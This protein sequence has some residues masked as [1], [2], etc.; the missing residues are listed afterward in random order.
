MLTVILM[1][2]VTSSFAM[3]GV[4]AI[5]GGAVS[6]MTLSRARRERDFADDLDNVLTEILGP[7]TSSQI[8]PSGARNSR[9]PSR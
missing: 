9:H 4:F 7:R 8:S 3:L 6:A 2:V 5:A 1:V